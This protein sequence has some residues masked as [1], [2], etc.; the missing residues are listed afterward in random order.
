MQRPLLRPPARELVMVMNGYDTDLNGKNEFYT[1]NGIANYYEN[2]RVFRGAS[3]RN[4]VP[5]NAS[6][7]SAA[8]VGA[9]G[10]RARRAVCVACEGRTRVSD[11][12]PSIS[13]Q[14][15][16]GCLP[17]RCPAR[18]LERASGSRA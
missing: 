1:V 17:P 13:S 3:L 16:H 10:I 15:T 4:G 7:R 6:W 12:Q 2:L 11:C 8:S 5:T 14:P 9:T 18:S